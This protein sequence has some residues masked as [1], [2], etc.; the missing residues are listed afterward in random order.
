MRKFDLFPKVSD[1]SFDV[2]TITGGVISIFT[3]I[4]LM[5]IAF[6]E[7]VS[8]RPN[9]IKQRA[10]FEDYR[11]VKPQPLTIFFNMTVSYPC[12][13]LH[14]SVQDVSGNHQMPSN[15]KIIR[16]RLDSHYKPLSQPIS[17][18]DPKSIFSSCGNCYGS[19]YSK[20]CLTCFDIAS[21]FMLQNKIVPNLDNFE[22]CKRDRKAIDD[23]EVCRLSGQISTQFSK[24]IILINAGGEMKLPV[25]FKHDLTY[26]GDNVNLSHYITELRFGPNFDYLR[27]PLDGG[28]WYQRGRGFFFYRYKLNLVK[29]YYE[30]NPNSQ[31]TSKKV[32]SNQYSAQFNQYKIEKTVSKR[33]P[34]I[35]FDFDT[36]PIAVQMYIEKK[37]TLKFITK[38]LAIIGGAFTLGGLFDSLVY[39]IHS[40]K[41]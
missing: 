36:A 40:Y 3:F 26:F 12:H 7:I 6:V 22:Q 20:C 33:H 1:D 34:G 30:G 10:I 5:F 39:S 21:S 9:K 4:T 8:N 19:N 31:S 28:R 32:I 14:I 35:A 11:T 16:Q 27:N 17:D 23:Q 13:L 18:S 38:L 41:E 37:S 25:H 29:T 15:Q 2:R 24:G